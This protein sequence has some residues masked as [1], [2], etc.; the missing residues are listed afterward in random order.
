MKNDL[1]V[2]TSLEETWK[3]NKEILF[4]GEWCKQLSRKPYWSKLSFKTVKYH[5]NNRNKLEEDYLYSKKLYQRL[6]LELGENLNDYYKISHSNRYWKIII[7]PWLLSFIQIILER[8]ENLKQ[9]K[10]YNEKFE[11][12]IIKINKNVVLPK[13]YESYSRLIMTDTWNH[14]IFSEI[15]KNSEINR[16]ILIEEKEFEDKENFKEYL[17][18]KHYSNQ[19]AIYSSFLNLFKSKIRNEKFHRK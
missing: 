8:Y 13:N 18:D 19:K 6:I 11:T 17:R 14:F 3:K 9:L 2:T 7:G 15:I 10:Y 5:W 4:L 12:I 1:L 16:R